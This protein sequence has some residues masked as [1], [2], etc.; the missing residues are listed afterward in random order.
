MEFS[1]PTHSLKHFTA[2]LKCFKSFSDQVHLNALEDCLK[3]SA[4]SPTRSTYAIANLHESY[5]DHYHLNSNQLGIIEVLTKPLYKILSQKTFH[6]SIESCQISIQTDHQSTH[7]AKRRHQTS[8][9]DPSNSSNR[10]KIQLFL[11]VGIIKSFSLQFSTISRSLN[12]IDIRSLNS[13]NY[14]ISPSNHLKQWIDHFISHPNLIGTSTS[15]LNTRQALE[16]NEELSFCFHS[17]GKVLMKTVNLSD[18]SDQ[19]IIVPR[20]NDIFSKGARQVSTVLTISSNEFEDYH[21]NFHSP[22]PS[23]TQQ[24]SVPEMIIITISMKEF[25]SIVELGTTIDAPIDAGFSMGGRPFYISI[26][27][28]DESLSLDFILASTGG[29]ELSG[30]DQ[31]RSDHEKSV[32]SSRPLNQTRVHQ[33]QAQEM[34]G[35]VSNQSRVS[36]NH[37]Q[38]VQSTPIA[39]PSRNNG[40]FRH[41]APD[42]DRTELN[43]QDEFGNEDEMNALDQLDEGQLEELEQQAILQSQARQSQRL[44]SQPSNSAIDLRMRNDRQENGGG[45]DDDDRLLPTQ[46]P[47]QAS[48]LP[49]G[50]WRLFD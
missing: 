42:P 19:S 6:A 41:E 25:R 21:V 30:L 48:K 43:G 26:S 47:E 20:I 13:P 31:I 10:I 44:Q 4:V 14:W 15:G 7:L 8:T 38:P 1:L 9:L 33:A 11:S 18:D 22:E 36:V 29:E 2:V 5:F 50:K 24:K 3:L 37:R 40:L 27:T 49:K 12:P 28:S 35:S 46:D 45:D 17:D 34:R 16:S 39:G 32:H 23:N